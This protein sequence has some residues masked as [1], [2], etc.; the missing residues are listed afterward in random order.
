M[1]TETVPVAVQGSFIDQIKNFDTQAIWQT[2][3]S[4]KI[5]WIQLGASFGI[6][7]L[8]GY[9][10]KKYLKTFLMVLA[11]GVVIVA[12]LDYLHLV[13]IDWDHLQN[14]IGIAPTQESLNN[15]F[16]LGLAWIK[17]NVQAV[18]SFSVGFTIGYKVI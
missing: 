17:S 12:T 5:D 2:I 7:V 9:L 8:A 10:C 3:K 4:Y 15:L 6:G 13:H 18:V 11:I 16:Q 14:M 1:N